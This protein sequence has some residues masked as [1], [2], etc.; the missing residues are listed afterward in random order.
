MFA[1][2][3]QLIFG[4]KIDVEGLLRHAE[5]MADIVN[6]DTTNTEAKEHLAGSSNNMYLLVLTQNGCKGTKNI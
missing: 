3:N 1:C 6:G 5:F 4:V 2:N